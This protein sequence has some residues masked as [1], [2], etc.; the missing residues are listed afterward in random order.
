MGVKLCK[1]ISLLKLPETLTGDLWFYSADGLALG[2]LTGFAVKRA[3]RSSLL[4]ATEELEDLLY[5]VV[6]RESPLL[7]RLQPADTLAAPSTVAAATGTFGEYLA[8]E[9]VNLEERSALLVDLEL[10]SR[11]YAFAALD[12]IGVGARGRYDGRPGVAAGTAGCTSLNT[13]FFSKEC[14]ACWPTPECW[15]GRAANTWSK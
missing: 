8:R 5:E 11:A 13:L 10:L 6:W 12:Q 7:D 9:G 3:S 4:S 2:G 1:K 14:C 15:N